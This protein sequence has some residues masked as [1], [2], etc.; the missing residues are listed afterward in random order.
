DSTH[1][2]PGEGTLARL[3]FDA[4][5][6][7][8]IDLDVQGTGQ[9]GGIAAKNTAGPMTLLIGAAR[10]I[11]SAEGAFG[12]RL[13]G[14]GVNVIVNGGTVTGQVGIDVVPAAVAASEPRIDVINS[15]T[16]T[17]FDKAVVG[18]SLADRVINSGTIKL[19]A[20]AP[21]VTVMD[22]GNGDDLYDGGSGIVTG[23]VKLGDGNDTAYG[24][25]QAETF[26]A[27]FGVNVIDGGGGDDTISYADAASGVFV[28]LA[29]TARQFTVASSDTLLNIEAI[30]GSDQA[31][32]LSGNGFS[33]TLTGGSGDDTLDGAFG[34]DRLDGGAGLDTARFSGS[35][36]ATVDL[37]KTGAQ[38]TGYGTDTLVG[39]ENLEGGSGADSLAGNDGANRLVGGAGNDT[40]AGGGG[41]DTL[42]GG[43]GQNT[44]RFS[45][46]KA[47]YAVTGDG[48]NASV[49]DLAGRDGQD[50]LKDVRL[51]QFT[52]GIV[53]LRNG[54]PT[55]VFL[56]TTSVLESAAPGATVA[57]IFGTDPDNDIISYTLV[58]DAG[59]LF[60]LN[61]SKLVLTR[62]LDYETAKLHA[63][64]V[65]ARDPYGATSTKTLTLTVRNV[66]ET[67]PLQLKGTAAG[68]TLSGESG[69]D[70]LQGFGGNDYLYGEAGNDILRG[71]AGNDVVFGGAGRD[72]FVLDTRPNAR[73][74]VDSFVDFAKGQDRIDLVKSIFKAIGRKGGLAKDAFHPGNHAADA[75][76]RILYDRK[77]GGL[78]YDPDGT[79][80]AAAIQIA[81]LQKNL[82]LSHKDFFVI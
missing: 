15:G 81:A 32:S 33:N 26:A 67:A 61:G 7:A 46:A 5:G 22:L 11:G 39:I 78:F 50:T 59:G 62:S 16:I 45:G 3:E 60:S 71:G 24:G 41:N 69:N 42:E 66:V 47:E 27:G 44:A 37:S 35:L 56:S 79:G 55:D 31:D 30:L 64:T 58:A 57:T 1:A 6:Y 70:L 40:L 63:V 12:L 49:T 20:G 36:G 73:R 4:A 23:I 51:L 75:Q 13:W 52:D 54:A 19:A 8:V 43:T 74:N 80:H 2:L 77:S 82:K 72:E 9:R 29:L 14:K 21:G 65:V 48:A 34:D 68:E 38:G 18:G 53:A 28:N 10:S 17:G 76:D 25:A